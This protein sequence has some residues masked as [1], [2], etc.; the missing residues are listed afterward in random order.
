MNQC[1]EQDAGED[2][3]EGEHRE[4]DQHH[5]RRFVRRAVV[6]VAVIVVPCGVIVMAMIVAACGSDAAQSP[7]GRRRS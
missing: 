6:A 1:A 7:R 2:R 3:A 5:P 4:R